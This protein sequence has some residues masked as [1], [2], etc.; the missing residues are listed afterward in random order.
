M[1]IRNH[2]N[3]PYR[4]RRYDLTYDGLYAM[5]VTRKLSFHQIARKYGAH[6]TTIVNA[7]QRLGIC[8]SQVV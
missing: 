5:R 4:P 7:C 3:A 2:T 1:K 8:R 6:H